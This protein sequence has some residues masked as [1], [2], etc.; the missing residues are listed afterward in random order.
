MRDWPSF[1]FGAC[2]LKPNILFLEK[3]CSIYNLKLFVKTCLID[4]FHN[5]DHIDFEQI[6]Y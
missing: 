2:G 4:I 6:Q 1:A 3:S 5:N